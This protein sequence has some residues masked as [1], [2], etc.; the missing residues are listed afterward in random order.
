[1]LHTH[2]SSR[3]PL[4]LLQTSQR[5]D[6][7][8]CCNQQSRRP[9]RSCIVRASADQPEAAAQMST[10]QAYTL[11]GVREGAGFEEILTA[12][13]KLTKS[14]EHDQDK[15]VRIETAYDILFMQ[16]MKKR[17]AGEGVAAK[18]RYADVA[19]RK[20]AKQAPKQKLPVR[21]EQLPSDTTLPASALYLALLI[22]TTAQGL[23][24]PAGRITNDA[25]GL[26]LAIALGA[27]VYLLS[28]KKRVPRGK[29]AGITVAGLLAGV[30]LGAALQSWLRVDIVPIGGLGSPAALISDFGI[31]AL[32]G[33]AL[34]LA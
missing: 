12:K 7:H 32:W 20:P 11:L 33:G 14:N 29:A 16:S 24:D 34:L 25:P 1:M 18:I 10:D 3:C 15:I 17:L 4:Q 8:R 19:K 31:L 27:S 22:W 26:Q 23:A 2:V 30:L 5:R 9:T 6:R 28:E 13:N 21:V